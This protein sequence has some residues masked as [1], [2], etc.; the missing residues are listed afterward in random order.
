[1]STVKPAYTISAPKKPNRGILKVRIKF[2]DTGNTY[3]VVLIEKDSAMELIDS[4]NS[5]FLAIAGMIL[6]DEASIEKIK[7]IL[8]E[9][10]NSGFF[11]GLVPIG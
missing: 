4:S 7:S 8:G 1:M 5:N 9:L 11:D 6:V 10:I 3:D 2:T